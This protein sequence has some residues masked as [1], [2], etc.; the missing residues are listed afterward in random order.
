MRQVF[1]NNASA[2]LAA[3]ISD[4]D[5][6]IQVGAGFGALFPNPG[7]SEYFLV[8]LENE[9]GDIEIC[10]CTAR[11][12]DNLTVL[13]AQEGT[14]AAAWTNG[15]TRVELRNTKGT[16]EVFLQ[17]GGDSMSGPLDMQGNEVQNSRLTGSTV[18]AGGIVAGAS[19]RGDE[20]DAS[21][22][23]V[24]PS[25]GGRPT[26]GGAQILVEGDNLGLLS[27]PVGS[28][29]MWYGSAASVPTGW[30]ICNGTNGTPDLRDRFVR[31]AG[32]TYT[33]GQTG[34]ANSAVPTAS[35]AGGHDHNA[36]TGDYTLTEANIPAHN[37]DLYVWQTGG[38]GNAESFSQ[39]SAKGIAGDADSGHTFGYR[40]TTVFGQ[41]LVKD[42]G[43]GV[44]AAHN[45]SIASEP[46]HTHA[47]GSIPTVP[48]FTALYYIMR[49]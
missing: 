46:D 35:A 13:R 10:R 8:S 45:H 19:I 7:A 4:T 28:V 12:G 48:A 37:H 33:E 6:T 5:T 31:G 47:I 44:A 29:I 41:K 49:V 2:L 40:N 9:L 30:Q 21:N 20:G 17:R 26:M 1:E 15:Q 32:L 43:S 25:G 18:M 27:F 11:V 39:S 38:Q 34:G 16:M 42:Y 23:I 3:S 22:E 24:V 36:V 14:S